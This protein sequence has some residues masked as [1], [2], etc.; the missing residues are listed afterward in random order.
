MAPKQ[1][2]Q[3]KGLLWNH[4]KVAQQVRYI[5]DART[6]MDVPYHFI[7]R[8]QGDGGWWPAVDAEHSKFPGDVTQLALT[9]KG[10]EM[11]A[12]EDKWGT[13]ERV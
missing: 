8:K 5:G 11:L 12:S 1:R 9:R 7:A 6:V 2:K 3:W 13:F 4:N 10:A